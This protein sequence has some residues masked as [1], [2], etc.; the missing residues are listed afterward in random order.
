TMEFTITEGPPVLP[1]PAGEQGIP[2]ERGSPPPADIAGP[3][4]W[5]DPKVAPVDTPAS[6]YG[7]GFT[8]GQKVQF[9]W[10]SVV[11]N[12]ISGTG[13][14]ET[15]VELG[16]A[17]ARADGS[18]SFPF[19]A[20]DDLG[21]S[22]RIEAFVNGAQAITT[23]FVVIPSVLPLEVTSGPVG[24]QLTIH[25][26]GVGWT[27]TANIYHLVYDNAYL[28]YACG[29]NS[30]GDVTIY[31]PITGKPGWHFIDLY[32]GIYKGTEVKGVRNFRVP[33]LTYEDDHPGERLPAFHF[34]IFVE[35]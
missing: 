27:E 15:S 19:T 17:T 10:Y 29:F 32:P 12:R 4:L 7:K 24:T 2:I 28:G 9:L 18:V 16:T 33:Q 25:L 20:P 5:V 31:L 26:K 22:H 30:Q 1:M 6:L 11:G 13:W 21:G 34:A 8:P 3:V 23:E 35:E 14:D